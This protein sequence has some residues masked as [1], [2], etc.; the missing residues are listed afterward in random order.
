MFDSKKLTQDQVALIKEWAADG[1]QLADIQK[2]MED[3]MQCKLTY[4]DTRFLVLDLGV[5]IRDLDEEARVLAQKEEAAAA[6]Q[7]IEDGSFT[8]TEVVDTEVMPMADTATEVGM[9]M[10]GR[11]SVTV[12]V[13]AKPGLM[14]SGRVNFTDGQAAMWYIDE[15]GLGLN[16]DLDGYQPTAADLEAFQLELQMA[17]ESR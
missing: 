16:P 13:I 7:A 15:R 3:D 5:T 2:R 4:M 1:A 10:G 8:E 14:A 11:V 6:A 12:D 17:M 9:G